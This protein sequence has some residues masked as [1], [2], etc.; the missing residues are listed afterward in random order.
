[1]RTLVVPRCTNNNNK[2]IQTIMWHKMSHGEL[3]NNYKA[4]WHV[5]PKRW[6]QRTEKKNDNA[7][8]C[9]KWLKRVLSTDVG[10]PVVLPRWSVEKYREIV[11]VPCQGTCMF[12][13]QNIVLSLFKR[14]DTV[15]TSHTSR[16]NKNLT[17]K[18]SQGRRRRNIY[19][20]VQDSRFRKSGAKRRRIH[21][22]TGNRNVLVGK[23]LIYLY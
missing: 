12:Y 9:G 5:G 2:I 7:S 20:L 16:K 19:D 17:L 18:K 14:T 10:V 15:W 8:K 13:F 11:A 3:T 6:K 21:E 1:M 4:V 23:K 22:F